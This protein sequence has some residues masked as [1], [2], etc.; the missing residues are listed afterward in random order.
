TFFAGAMAGETANLQPEPLKFCPKC[1]HIIAM[2]M[3]PIFP[4]AVSD[5]DLSLRIVHIAR[6]GQRLT[7]REGRGE[8]ERNSAVRQDRR[9]GRRVR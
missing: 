5:I 2:A 7:S 4:E 8:I 9:E 1:P 3:S 6:R